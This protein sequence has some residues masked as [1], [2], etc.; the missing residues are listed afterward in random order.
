MAT[1]RNTE[2]LN[3]FTVTG[4]VYNHNFRTGM[5][6]PTAKWHPNERYVS[7]RLNVLTDDEGLNVVPVNFFV[8]ENKTDRDGNVV[9]DETYKTLTQIMTGATFEDSGTHAQKVRVSGSV[10]SNDFYSTRNDEVVQAQ[11]VNGRFVH[12]VQPGLSVTPAKFDV[13][14]VLTSAVYRE[15]EGRDPFLDIRGYVFNYNGSRVF[16]FRCECRDSSGIS[17]IEG[18]EPSS[19]NPATCHVW[20]EIQNTVIEKPPAEQEAVTSGFGVRPTVSGYDTKTVLSWVIVGADTSDMPE[21]GDHAVYCRDGMKR[22]VDERNV[23][24]EQVKQ[25][26]MARAGKAS[27]GAAPTASYRA[28]SSAGAAVYDSDL[29]F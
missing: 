14:T 22:L 11:R 28:G 23:R 15:V 6:K 3:D 29:P 2:F 10:D 24:L 13:K 21:F 1:K 4:Y 17:F 16:P 25:S 12:I 9:P 8:Y 26:G 18:L 5:S 19:S 20:G 7:G 27:F